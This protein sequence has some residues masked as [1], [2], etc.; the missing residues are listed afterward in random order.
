MSVVDTSF[1]KTKYYSQPGSIFTKQVDYESKTAAFAAKDVMSD[2][3]KALKVDTLK[4]KDTKRLGKRPEWN[5]STQT[6]PFTA[7]RNKM[8]TLSAV[9]TFVIVLHRFCNQDVFAVS[10]RETGL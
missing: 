9:C 2:K 10:K 5:G 7:Q 8:R 3:V 6:I 1:S 4:Y